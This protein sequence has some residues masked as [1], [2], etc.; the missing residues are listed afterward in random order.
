MGELIY[1]IRRLRASEPGGN[2]QR[3]LSD[4]YRICKVLGETVGR[5]GKMKAPS[6]KTG[7]ALLGGCMVRVLSSNQTLSFGPLKRGPN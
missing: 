1:I 5:E 2:R 6:I 3:I 7:G 4:N